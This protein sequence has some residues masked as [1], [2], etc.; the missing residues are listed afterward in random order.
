MVNHGLA[1]PDDWFF[2]VD[3]WLKIEQKFQELEVPKIARNTSHEIC[4]TVHA[5]V[6]TTL[7]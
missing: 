7:R 6:S 1:M 3:D 2:M 4:H 5:T